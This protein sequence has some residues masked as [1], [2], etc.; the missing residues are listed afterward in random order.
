MVGYITCAVPNAQK[1][2]GLDCGQ[3]RWPSLP[4]KIRGYT[5]CCC[6]QTAPSIEMAFA[7]NAQTNLVLAQMS[8]LQRKQLD[9]D[10]DGQFSASELASGGF[11]GF[12]MSATGP[13]RDHA[14]GDVATM[15]YLAA[16][17]AKKQ[18]YRSEEQKLT[19]H[20]QATGYANAGP[21]SF[22]Y[23]EVGRSS[24]PM[25]AH[26]TRVFKDQTKRG[27]HY[28]HPDGHQKLEQGDPCAA[29]SGC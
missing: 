14:A 16:E 1:E 25:H 24:L 28:P 4:L 27:E 7:N 6:A 3:S 29:R 23:Y 21:V 11:R 8:K 13:A 22:G 5:Q 12:N 19:D 20:H 2:G 15:K 26:E 9:K 17:A 18:A 10:G